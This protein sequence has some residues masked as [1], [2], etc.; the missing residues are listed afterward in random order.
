MEMLNRL[1][2]NLLESLKMI[3]M[4]ILMTMIGFVFIGLFAALMQWLILMCSA[5]THAILIV[6]FTLLCFVVGA[7]LVQ[8]V[9]G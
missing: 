9:K 3:G 6:G 7:L 1:F 8:C 2:I 5:Y 4:M